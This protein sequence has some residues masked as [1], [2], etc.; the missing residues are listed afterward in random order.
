MY[1][2]L[3][4][5]DIDSIRLKTIDENILPVY[6]HTF[7]DSIGSNSKLARIFRLSPLYGRPSI[8]RCSRWR[9]MTVINFKISYLYQSSL[10]WGT[11]NM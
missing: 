4:G 8:P 9:M 11:Y 7:S 2:I 5:R 10:K 1:E 6:A 3:S